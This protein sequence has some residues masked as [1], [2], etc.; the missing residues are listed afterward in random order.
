MFHKE[1]RKIMGPKE[2]MFR[3]DYSGLVEDG[4]PKC[5]ARKFMMTEEIHDATW[6]DF[7]QEE[8]IVD[9]DRDWGD[10]N[11]QCENCSWTLADGLDKVATG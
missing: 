5:G 2:K 11:I 10:L 3:M 6:W 1:R 9:E 4:C 7:D 8:P